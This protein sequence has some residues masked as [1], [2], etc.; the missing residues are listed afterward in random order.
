M[1]ARTEI[2]LG[3]LGY[4]M[5]REPEPVCQFPPKFRGELGDVWRAI[6]LEIGHFICHWSEFDFP[7]HLHEVGKLLLG[8]KYNL[9]GSEGFVFA[10]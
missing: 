9:D 2:F 10:F 6:W 1:E 8:F 7:K 4:V 5:L 3:T